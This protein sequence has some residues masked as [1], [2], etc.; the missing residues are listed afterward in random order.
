MNQFQSSAA[1]PKQLVQNLRNEGLPILD[2]FLT[3]SIKIRESHD[4]AK[5]MIHYAPKHALTQAFIQIY[6]AIQAQPQATLPL[7]DKIWKRTAED[8]TEDE[9]L[10]HA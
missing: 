9:A 3:A 5:P 10:I 1:L 8:M 7:A 6:E 4:A 2:P